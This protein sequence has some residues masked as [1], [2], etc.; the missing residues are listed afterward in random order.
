MCLCM[1][2]VITFSGHNKGPKNSLSGSK[3]AFSWYF[4]KVSILD[5]FFK[6]I[7]KLLKN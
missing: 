2:S 6:C 5:S 7:E 4:N 3:T 1:L